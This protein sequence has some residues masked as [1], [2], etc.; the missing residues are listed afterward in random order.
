M[1]VGIFQFCPTW[2][3]KDGN[4]KKIKNTLHLYSNISLWVL[5]ELSTTGYQFISATEVDQLSEPF[6]DGLT[7]K[8]L[9]D[10]S[11]DTGSAIIIGI[12]EKS[13]S[14]IYNSAGI[15]NKGEILGIYRKIHLFSE[16]KRWF[17]PG[18]RKPEVYEIDGVKIGVMI[19]FD[20]IFPEIARSL[21]ISGAQLIAHPSNLILPYCQDAMI[22]RSL[23]NRVFTITANRIGTE[24]RDDK[25][26]IT[27]SGK[28]QIV[29]PKGY[30][31]GQLSTDKEEVLI[32]DIN[33]DDALDKFITPVNNIFKDRK[34]KLYI[35]E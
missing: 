19:C 10:L 30:K 28:S 23:E 24:K 18:D 16:E 34:P 7:S 33:P 5:P 17:L 15:F 25:L 35:N 21:A 11:R 6:P 26:A 31:I 9:A 20:W 29:D 13:D 14:G 32:A 2:G 1:K 4:L 8:K 27:F 22:T 12:L 3:D